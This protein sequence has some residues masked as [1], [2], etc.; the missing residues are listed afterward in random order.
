MADSPLNKREYLAILNQKLDALTKMLEATK[1]L[2][3]TGEGDE[4]NLEREAELF[5]SLYEQRADVI[6]KIQKM[7]EALER[8][9]YVVVGLLEDL[10]KDKNF[11]KARQTIIDRLKETAK[12]MVDLDKQHLTMSENLMSFVRGNL[13]KIRDGRDASTAYTDTQGSTSGYH[14]DKTN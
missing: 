5:T 7:D 11:A 4:E 9:E 13:K 12:A 1:R 10:D 3:L 14:F 8:S 2:N 6:T